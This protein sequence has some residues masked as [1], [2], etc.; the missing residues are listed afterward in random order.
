MRALLEGAIARDRPQTRGEGTCVEI[1]SAGRVGYAEEIC[2]CRE[3]IIITTQ[4]ASVRKK[5]HSHCAFYY[6]QWKVAR[7]LSNLRL[8]A[9]SS[10]AV[11]SLHFED[12]YTDSLLAI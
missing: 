4:M 12:Q 8:H 10:R 3:R 5:L 6:D 1:S 2:F 9:E 7:V 11:E